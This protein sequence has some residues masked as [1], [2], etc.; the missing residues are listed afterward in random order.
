MIWTPNTNYFIELPKDTLKEILDVML[1]DIMGYNP[2]TE[3]ED[4]TIVKDNE[5]EWTFEQVCHNLKYLEN[6]N[7]ACNIQ[8]R[9]ANEIDND[10]VLTHIDSEYFDLA[11][12]Y[13]QTDTFLT[14]EQYRALV[15]L[16]TEI[17][18]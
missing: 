14:E 15:P 3:L 8:L 2:T 16:E 18:I 13:Y 6:G 7:I 17:L 9:N 10:N 4:G 1:V 11:V 12:Y 5:T